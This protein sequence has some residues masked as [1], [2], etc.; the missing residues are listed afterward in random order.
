MTKRRRAFED[1]RVEAVFDAYPRKARAR[2]LA[3][4]ELIFETAASLDGV[5]EIEESLRWSEPAYLT[6]QTKSGTTIRMDWKEATPDRVHL[7]FHCQTTLVE[8][9]RLH[10]PETFEFEGN[11]GLSLAI[12]DPLPEEALSICIAEALTYHRGRAP[13]KKAARK[14]PAHRASAR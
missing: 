13:T 9:F 1:R 6:S 2:L 7:F 12:A 10:F 14:K 5:G 3:M 11:R 8:T 4:R